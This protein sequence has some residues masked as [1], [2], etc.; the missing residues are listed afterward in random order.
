MS[1]VVTGLNHRTSELA[2][3]E[4]VVISDD[5]QPRA[6]IEL[7]KRFEGAGAVIVSTCNRSEVYVHH[8][9]T[10]D[11]IRTGIEAFL[12]EWGGVSLEELNPALYHHEARE[13][14]AHLF[15]V[16]SSLDSLVVGEGQILGQVHDAYQAAQREQTTDKVINQLF[17]RGFTIA[18]K[19]RTDTRIGEGKVSVSSVAVDLA[20]SIFTELAGK[21]VMVIGTGEMAE[22]TLRSL[23]EK[24]ARDVIV[25]NRSIENAASLAGQ[26]H[27]EAV[28]LADVEDHLHRADV[29]ISSTG[30]G[31][32][33]LRADHFRQALRRR[34][35][36]PIFVIDIAV[37]RDVDA[38]VNAL[39]NVYLY[40][41]D[42]LKKVAD[43]N[44]EARRA[45]VDRALAIVES[46]ADQFMRWMNS[47]AAEPTI[48]SLGEELDAIRRR[49][50]EKTRK[51]LSH[52]S[53][54]DW[55][56]IDYMMKRY[57]ASVLQPAL[58]QL[59]EE[60]HHEDHGTV[61]QLVRRLFGLKEST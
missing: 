46:G 10:A 52:I 26:Y 24:G 21:T 43:E 49:E 19:V 15:R 27:G 18:K 37:P 16:A 51:R 20:V 13:A 32:V 45:E 60:I 61:I 17:Q 5:A 38:Q 2:L 23:I 12:A 11:D 35:N 7:R 25:A 39:D 14:A 4:R 59:K 44:V 22:L 3:R 8:A 40:D 54:Q 56:E 33:V 9:T 36:S 31:G 55:E 47:L 50:L 6:L 28:A 58:T 42:D 29:V 1:L 57:Q 41:I 34:T 30:S 48:R 53:P